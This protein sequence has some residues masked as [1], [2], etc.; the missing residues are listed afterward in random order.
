[1]AGDLATC[2]PLG[3]APQHSASTEGIIDRKIARISTPPCDS[4]SPI[5]GW[6]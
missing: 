5:R 1:M 4:F 6:L 3:D 2:L